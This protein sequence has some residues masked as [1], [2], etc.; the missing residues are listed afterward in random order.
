MDLR[1]LHAVM[2]AVGIGAALY[3]GSRLPVAR[4]WLCS[5]CP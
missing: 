2:G 3:F 5:C 1:D 4:G